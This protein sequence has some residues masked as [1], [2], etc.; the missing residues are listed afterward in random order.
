MA[1]RQH[2]ESA[3]TE[4][5]RLIIKE[6]FGGV[7]SRRVR[8]QQ[9]RTTT[10]AAAVRKSLQ[11]L[12]TPPGAIDLSTLRLHYDPTRS[13]DRS[14]EKV[15]SLGAGSFG[16]VYQVRS[17]ATGQDRAMKVLAK[18]L[19]NED[20]RFVETEIEAMMRLDHPNVV[21]FYQFF[22]RQ[23]AIFI[24]TEFCSCGD[25]GELLD[26]KCALEELRQLFRDVM[27]GVAYCHG[28]GIAHRDL[29]FQNCLLTAGVRRR[30]AKVIDFGLSAIR[31]EGEEDEAWLSETLGTRLFVA[32]EVIKKM[33][34]GVKCDLWALGV[35]LY[36]LLTNQHPFSEDVRRV[37]TKQLLR[38]VCEA[39]VRLEPLQAVTVDPA[40][41]ALARKLLVQDPARRIDATSALQEG[42]L[43]AS[44]EPCFRSF[45]RMVGAEELLDRLLTFADLPLFF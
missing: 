18:T 40:A 33:R 7:A 31:L 11:R 42:W 16:A 45:V 39:N 30:V 8:R 23:R 26:G 24:I 41:R 6:C 20:M 22:E 12:P 2:S 32:P 9:R 38:D 3:C 36:I 28:L 34:Y 1:G 21:K 43:Q 37:P 14:Y 25:F 15:K 35:M 27:M 19:V 10:V 17:M 13:M 5:F 29:K 4:I 44:P